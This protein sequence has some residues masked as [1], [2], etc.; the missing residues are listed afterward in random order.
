MCGPT[1]QQIQLGDEEMQAYQ[2][3]MQLTQQQYGN[4]QA[5]LQPMAQQFQ[6]IFDKGPNQEGYSQGEQDTL[7]SQVLAGTAE[8][9]QQAATAVNESEAAQGGGNIP[10]PSGA[11]LSRREQVAES[12]AQEE[13]REET[14]VREAGYTQGLQEYESAAAGLGEVAGAENPLGYESAETSSGGTANEEENT[15]ASE[16]NSWVNAAIGAVGSVAGA[17]ASHIGQH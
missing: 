3:A 6:S 7:N 12:A 4:Q 11:Q 13:S 10:L 16:Q 1:G 2:Q 14:G 9:Y 5:I 15:I 8:N 17:A